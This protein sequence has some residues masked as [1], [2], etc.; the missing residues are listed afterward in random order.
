MTRLDTAQ[1][2]LD[3]AIARIEA[4]LSQ[5]SGATEDQAGDTQLAAALDAALQDNARLREI[6]GT[7][8][9]RLDSTIVRLEHLLKD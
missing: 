1:Q 6:T 7:V 2:R 9:S 4:A 5:R 3:S 8:S